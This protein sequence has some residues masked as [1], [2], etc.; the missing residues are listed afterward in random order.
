M[1]LPKTVI[2]VVESHPIGRACM[3][4]SLGEAGFQTIA[5]R[6]ATEAIAILEMR[7]NIAIIFNETEIPETMDGRHVEFHQKLIQFEGYF[8]QRVTRQ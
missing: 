7:S 1:S 5:V 8:N 2:L 6:G 4:E 3:T